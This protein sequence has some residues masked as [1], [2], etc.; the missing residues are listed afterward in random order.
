MKV[1]LISLALIF[2]IIGTG[3]FIDKTYVILSMLIS[4]CSFFYFGIQYKKIFLYLTSFI[5][6][7]SIIL[8]F[9]GIYNQNILML[10]E[11]YG[12]FFLLAGFFLFGV[13]MDTSEFRAFILVQCFVI[14]AVYLYSIYSGGLYFYR[15]EG[16]FSTPNAFGRFAAYSYILALFSI[17]F[18]RQFNEKCRF[19][20]ILLKILLVMSVMML[21]A[22]NSRASIL[23]IP[24]LLI[25]LLILKRKFLILFLSLFSL[26][27][28]VITFGEYLVQ[29]IPAFEKVIAYSDSGNMDNGRYELWVRFSKYVNWLE[30]N[31]RSIFSGLDVHNNFL[32]LSIRFG[33]INT[34]LFYSFLILIP[35]YVYY[36]HNNRYK[37][38]QYFSISVMVYYFLYSMVETALLIPILLLNL[39]LFGFVTFPNKKSLQISNK[40][41]KDAY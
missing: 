23:V 27:L 24:V 26:I 39:L 11:L 18:E 31:D 38:L 40:V 6:I 22:S 19:M 21:F 2:N 28:F 16:M 5:I 12:A 30:F 34:T 41:I 15:Y 9:T 10:F 33:I 3:I 13:S 29:L 20:T 4:L 14:M 8:L 37:N 25:C 36:K 7:F 1:L 17:Y 35:I 32:N